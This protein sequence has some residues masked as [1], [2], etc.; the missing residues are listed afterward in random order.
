MWIVVVAVAP[1]PLTAK[2]QVV[3]QVAGACCRHRIAS[4]ACSRSRRSS[5]SPPAD[6]APTLK[7]VIV[8]VAGAPARARVGQRP[9]EHVGRVVDGPAA[10]R[11][12]ACRCRRRRGCRSLPVPPTM[13]SLPASP[14]STSLPVPPLMR[15]VAVAAADQV[16]AV[17]AVTCRCRQRVDEVV[18]V[19]AGDGVVA[20]AG[21][22]V[23]RVVGQQRDRRRVVARRRR[24]LASVAT[25]VTVSVVPLTASLCSR[26]AASVVR[27]SG[28]WW[29]ASRRR[30]RCWCRGSASRRWA[31][32]E[33]CTRS[34]SDPSV[35]TSVASTGRF[36]R[37][38]AAAALATRRSACS[39]RPP[40]ARRPPASPAPAACR[41]RW[42]ST[43]VD[44]VAVGGDGQV[45]RAGMSVA[46]G[47][48]RQ[49]GERPARHLDAGVAGGGG[50][51]AACR[52]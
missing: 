49:V 23:G 38:G 35:S 37:R 22:V 9:G 30:C 17:A 2:S 48:R 40:P 8:S 26:P 29:R 32:R 39:A 24:V 16:V 11:R 36:D 14:N 10:R 25:A 43:P 15:V 5:T 7:S 13:M 50:E 27:S 21:A 41:W 33:T 46:G 1:L 19:V 6:T 28:R 3:G 18:A 52:R 45:D 51:A 12:S 47:V 4:S 44:S 31:R 34:V 20:G 42:P